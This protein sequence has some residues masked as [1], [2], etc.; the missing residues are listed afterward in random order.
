[1]TF[2]DNSNG[3]NSCPGYLDNYCCIRL[4]LN[5]EQSAF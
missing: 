4:V 1:M 5:I 2:I 3:N